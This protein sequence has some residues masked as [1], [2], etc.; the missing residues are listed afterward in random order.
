[1]RKAAGILTIIGGIIGIVAGGIFAT[2]GA[3][4]LIPA[5]AG[6]GGGFIALGVVALIGG[7]YALRGRMWG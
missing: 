6:V 4:A 2:G 3:W 7:I 5:L 1:M